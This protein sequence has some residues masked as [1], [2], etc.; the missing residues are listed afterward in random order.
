MNRDLD[1]LALLSEWERAVV[2]AEAAERLGML[3][4]YVEKDYWV[5]LVL[6]VLFNDYPR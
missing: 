1:R 6:D 4:G 2:F 3:P 5:C